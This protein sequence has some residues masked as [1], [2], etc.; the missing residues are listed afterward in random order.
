M[1]INTKK[2]TSEMKRLNIT[3]EMLGQMLK[4]PRTR[5]A[6]AYVIENGKTFS[7]I[8]QIAKALNLDPKD[9]II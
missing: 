5:Q 6:G 7:V 1:E 2:I 3:T 4:P 9:L 8:E